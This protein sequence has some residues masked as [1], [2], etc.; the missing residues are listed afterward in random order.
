MHSC[1]IQCL[2]IWTK[3][4]LNSQFTKLNSHVLL[5]VHDWLASEQT[6]LLVFDVGPVKILKPVMYFRSRIALKSLRIRFIIQFC[7]KI[8]NYITDFKMF[9]CHAYKTT[10][11]NNMY[12]WCWILPGDDHPNWGEGDDENISRWPGP[13]NTQ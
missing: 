8:E 13:R 3:M 12:I 10:H 2:I 7:K 9:I 5:T 6:I 1:K 4:H 11:Q